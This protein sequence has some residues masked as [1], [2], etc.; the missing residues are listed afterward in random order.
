MLKRRIEAEE[1]AVINEKKIIKRFSFV[2]ASVI[3]VTGICS[4]LL[5][6]SYWDK[7]SAVDKAMRSSRQVKKT[8]IILDAKTASQSPATVTIISAAPTPTTNQENQK[9]RD[10]S[11]TRSTVSEAPTDVPNN[12]QQKK[13]DKYKL[14]EPQKSDI[15]KEIEK[16]IESAISANPNL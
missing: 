10:T 7:T 3:L 16:S 12:S 1:N 9:Y 13:A 15:I 11:D 4:L 6:N 5:G 2:F 14:T 8:D